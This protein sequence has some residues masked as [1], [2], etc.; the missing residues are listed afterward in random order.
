M[1]K[2]LLIRHWKSVDFTVIDWILELHSRLN[3]IIYIDII[4]FNI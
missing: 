3:E 1:G 2:R 4:L